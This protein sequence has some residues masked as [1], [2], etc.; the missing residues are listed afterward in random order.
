MPDL[1]FLEDDRW[2]LWQ[3]MLV[4]AICRTRDISYFRTSLYWILWGAIKPKCLV[5]SVLPWKKIG[6][7][8]PLC[9]EAKKSP[10]LYT[11]YVFSKPAIGQDPAWEF[12]WNLCKIDFQARSTFKPI[13]RL[14]SVLENRYR[15]LVV[16][17][18]GGAD[19]RRHCEI[20]DRKSCVY[21]LLANH[22]LST[23][24]EYT[25]KN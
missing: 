7:L 2:R 21:D 10:L 13:N 18:E 17:F 9:Q 6:A 16:Y 3:H 4:G 23:I 11:F 1:L 22:S 15:S 20:R 8:L 12:V 14:G 25:V 19:Q 24:A 5:G